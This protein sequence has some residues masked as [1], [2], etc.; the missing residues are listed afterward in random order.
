MPDYGYLHGQHVTVNMQEA[1]FESVEA[2]VR[3][4]MKLA[5]RNVSMRGQRVR[6][7]PPRQ[8]EFSL[9]VQ[10]DVDL[11]PG[12]QMEAEIAYYS[13]EPKDVEGQLVVQVGRADA[14]PDRPGEGESIVIPVR[15]MLPGAKLAVAPV[16]FGTVLP[17]Q[18]KGMSAVVTNTGST[19]GK[20]TVAAP[21]SGSK[22]SVTPLEAVIPPGGAATF[23]CELKCDMELGPLE[24]RLPITTN[25]TMGF[26]PKPT[27]VRA[28]VD[29]PTR[30]ATH[31]QSYPHADLPTRRPTHTQTYPH[32]DPPTRRA[33]HT[34]TYPHA[35]LPSP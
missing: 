1:N 9:H 12:L 25:G 13:E 26:V 4:V 30:R 33:T 14:R 32:A 5:V 10:N 20:F 23:R 17:G 29:L 27:E 24:M 11:A 15:A 21:P 18:S 31:T 34:Q 3:H 35:D 16:Q 8:S 28:P 6:L 7:V 19:D 2:G 22:F